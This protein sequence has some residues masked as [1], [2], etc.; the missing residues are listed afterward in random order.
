MEILVTKTNTMIIAWEPR[1]CKIVISEKII[2]QFAEFNYL[3]AIISAYEDLKNVVKNQINKSARIAGA[4]RT[5][6]WRNK[7]I[8]IKSKIRIYKAC[9]RP[10]LTYAA[11]IRADTAQTKRM[12]RTN[13]MRVHAQICHGERRS[14]TGSQE[15]Q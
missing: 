8:S 6:I 13:E 12:Y 3:G 9:V 5:T 2:K 10:V 11:K 7:H 14:I 4:L 1:R 15:E